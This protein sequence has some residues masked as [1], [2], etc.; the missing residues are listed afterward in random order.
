MVWAPPTYA[1]QQR[2]VATYMCNNWHECWT[3]NII[4]WVLWTVGSDNKKAEA[5]WRV[6]GRSY[7]WDMYL[8]G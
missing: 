5:G 7:A 8:P 1:V 3:W 6:A 2:F 4:V